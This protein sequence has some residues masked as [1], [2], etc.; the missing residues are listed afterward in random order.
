M[1]YFLLLFIQVV[2]VSPFWTANVAVF[3]LVILD[4]FLFIIK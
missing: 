3:L 4:K 1:Y 2:I